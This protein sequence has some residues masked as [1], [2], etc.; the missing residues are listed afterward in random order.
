MKCNKCG[1]EAQDNDKFCG[2]CGNEIIRQDANTNGFTEFV[3][4]IINNYIERQKKNLAENNGKIEMMIQKIISYVCLLFM[5]FWAHTG[6]YTF[7]VEFM[8]VVDFKISPANIYMKVLNVSGAN[9]NTAFYVIFII[10]SWVFVVMSMLNFTE[11]KKHANRFWIKLI[12]ALG[13]RLITMIRT[14]FVL[15]SWNISIDI[16]ER[17]YGNVNIVEMSGASIFFAI[18]SIIGIAVTISFWR[19]NVNE[20]AAL[21]EEDEES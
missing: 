3:K 20:S 15:Q 4:K 18:L 14:F 17:E 1:T 5:I 12:I 21:E 19:Q 7:P 16:I 2:N 13:L 6:V 9:T 11:C 10:A 8:D